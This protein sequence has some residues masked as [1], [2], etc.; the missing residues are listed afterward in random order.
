VGTREGAAALG[1]DRSRKT[2][3]PDELPA[4]L[5]TLRPHEIEDCLCIYKAQ[6]GQL[7]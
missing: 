4:P 7:R 3:R 2:V 1:I 5:R 6:L